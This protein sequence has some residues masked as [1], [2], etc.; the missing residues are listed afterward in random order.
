MRFDFTHHSPVTDSEI[1]EAERIINSEIL[2][3][4]PVDISEHSKTEAQEL[5][6]KA[7]FDEK[8]GDVVRVVNVPGFS[9]E[10]CGGLHVNRTGDIGSFKILREESIGSGTRRILATTGMNV[11]TILQKLFSLRNSLT[12]LLS[13]DEENLN[14][15]AKN[16]IEEMDIVR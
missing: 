1:A 16:L 8:Y 11:L 9:M 4:T 15:K 6:A 5:G 12:A 3:N 10:L 7:L 14:D 13:T 2:K